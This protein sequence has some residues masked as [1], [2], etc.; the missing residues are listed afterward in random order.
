[1]TDSHKSYRADYAVVGS[2]IAGLRAAIASLLLDD[3]RRKR[4]SR[5]AREFA[6][7]EQFSD[8]AAELAKLIVG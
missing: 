3:A 1:M 6:R 8:R 4:M 2:G 7:R 5:E